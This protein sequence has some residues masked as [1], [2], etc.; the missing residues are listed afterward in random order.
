MQT[1]P[2]YVLSYVLILALCLVANVS[3]ATSKKNHVIRLTN[4]E[5]RPNQLKVKVGEAVTFIN[6]D[7]FKHDVDIV[8][9]ANPNDV[10]VQATTMSPGASTTV[11]IEEKG[12]F[13]IYCTIHGGMRGKI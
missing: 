12:L 10:L 5:F 6:Q 7:K 13:T 3:A 9:T 8:R 11:T 1:R 4:I 2:L